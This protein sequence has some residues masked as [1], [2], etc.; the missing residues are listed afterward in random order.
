MSRV[1]DT[2]FRTREATA[3]LVAAG[4]RPHDLT[5]DL[6]CAVIKQ[7]SRTTIN[8]E[9]KPWKDEQ[10]DALTNAM[11]PA[12]AHA[13]LNIWAVAV[14]HGEKVFDQRREEAETQ[15]AHALT[16]IEILESKKKQLPR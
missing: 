11:P 8:D 1:N 10:A 7:G 3:R 5:V 15:L 14:E 2:R 9:L 13:M 6:I 16:C 12:V 4:R